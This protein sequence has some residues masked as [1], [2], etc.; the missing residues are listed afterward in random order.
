MP[1]LLEK[2]RPGKR[3]YLVGIE[4]LVVLEGP[5]PAYSSETVVIDGREERQGWNPILYFLALEP[6]ASHLTSLHLM[7]ARG[8]HRN[9]C[10]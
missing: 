2:G 10:F 5:G 7:Y 9:Q 3:D 4:S 8:P 6:W 1:I